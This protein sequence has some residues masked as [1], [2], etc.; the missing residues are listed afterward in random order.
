MTSTIDMK[1]FKN[2]HTRDIFRIV[3]IISNLRL[4]LI[5]M[6]LSPFFKNKTNLIRALINTFTVCR[7]ARVLIKYKQSA[8]EQK[9]P[10]ISLLGL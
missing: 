9:G 2:A 1:I 4:V 8:S 7:L 5:K 6:Q 3:L 10:K